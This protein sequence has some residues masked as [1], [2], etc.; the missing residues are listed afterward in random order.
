MTGEAWL[1]DPG[2]RNATT[3]EHDVK[4]TEIIGESLLAVVTVDVAL[5]VGAKF[6]SEL[7]PRPVG[8]AQLHL[9]VDHMLL[10]LGLLKWLVFGEV[11]NHSFVGGYQPLAFASQLQGLAL[12]AGKQDDE[13]IRNSQTPLEDGPGCG[14]GRHSD[15]T[16]LHHQRQA[17]GVIRPADLV[18]PERR[19]SREFRLAR[20]DLDPRCRGHSRPPGG[21]GPR[22]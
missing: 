6:L 21:R 17:R 2:D 22:C 8:L 19:R 5:S 18:G 3:L 12:G 16:S 10:L 9:Q 11:G 15:L 1:E 14:R 20:L 7:D 4:Q 13:V